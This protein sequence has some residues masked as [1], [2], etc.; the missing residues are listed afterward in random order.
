[1]LTIYSASAGTGKTHTLTGEYISLLFNGKEQYRHVLAVTFTNKA[2]AEMKN[3]ILEELFCLADDQPSHYLEILSENGKRSEM[4]IRRQ[5]KMILRYILHDYSA[6]HISTIDHFFQQTLRAFTREIGLQGNYQIELDDELMLEKAVESMFSELEKNENKELMNWLL[7]FTGN[8]IEESGGWDI[9]RDIIQ[10]GK[11]LFKET[12]KTYSHQIQEEIKEKQ[13]LSG[14]RD[15]LYQIIQSTRTAAKELGEKGVF[16]MQQHGMYPSDFKGGSRSVFFYFE[17]IA[18]GEMIEIKN[19][20]RALVDNVDD[21]VTKTASFEK[22]QAAE[23]IYINGMND[24]IREVITF[25]DNLTAYHTA[26]EIVRNFYTLGILTDLSQHIAKWRE[27]NNRMLIA[28]TTELLHKVIDGSE[29]P[30]IYEKTGAR[31]THYMIDEFQDTSSM[32]WSNFRPLLKD[33]LDSGRRNLIVGDVKQSIYRFRN[34]DWTLLDR[35]VKVDFKNRTNEKNLDVNWRSCRHIVQFNNMLFNV[36]P[37]LLQQSYND[38]V[39]QSSLSEEEK[40][41]Y[42]SLIIAA[43]KNSEQQVAESLSGKDGHVSIRFLPDEDERSWKQQSMEQLPPIIEQLQD[44]GYSLRDMAILTRTGAEGL[45][46]AETLLA[47]KETHPESGYKYDIISED[48]LTVNSSLSVRWLI[49]MIR[50][51]S[52]GFQFSVFSFQ[53]HVN[54]YYEKALLMYAVLK[55]KKTASTQASAINPLY[56]PFSPEI[57]T[58]LKRLSTRSLYEV[59]EGLFRLFETDFPDNELVFI[60]AFLD[61]V[62]EY[63]VN[64]TADTVQF[65]VWWDETGHR[66]KIITPD[67]QNAIRIMT[68][69]KSKGLGFNVVIMPFADWKVDQKDA[70]LWCHPTQKPFDQMSLVPVKYSK[71]LRNT[72]FAPDY[73]KEKLHAC[74]D[75]LNA[76]YVAFTRAKEELIVIA[77]QPKKETSTIA[78]LLWNSLT[79]DPQF[80]LD[81]ESGVY[82]RGSLCT[83][84]AGK[85][86]TEIEEWPMKRFHSLSPDDRMLLRFHRKGDS[87][88][89]EKRNLL[90]EYF[91][92]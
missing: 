75:N 51:L 23:R 31:I 48:S 27:D 10:L 15:K 47:Y 86:S 7:Q 20:F 78:S 9:R 89:D 8:K 73:F 38:D 46:A 19:T 54:S 6:F 16:L 44:H 42:Q 63:A 65:L 39:E 80:Q 85:A 3:R 13:F 64:E 87:L 79:T 18:T 72:I 5:A 52:L 68:I 90:M 55:Q 21:Y 49:E 84:V 43:Y 66:K 22:R 71:A 76:L 40:E 4:E 33:S 57:I 28:D 50:Y 61:M 62:A 70:I 11:Q 88:Y 74:M 29:I 69:H 53:S 25:F 12:Y 30:F 2:T 81:T 45:A 82:E 41:R 32:Q 17:R 67:T 92:S 35:Q 91:T 58:Q 37:L 59:A 26:T 34:S 24:L 83:S 1:M 77:P 36:V 56:Q 14:Y 60:Q